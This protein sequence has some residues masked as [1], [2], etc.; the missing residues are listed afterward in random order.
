MEPLNED[1]LRQISDPEFKPESDAIGAGGVQV[2]RFEA[3]NTGQTTLELA[4]RRWWEKAV[5][6][7]RTYSIQVIVR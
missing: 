1:V 6:P 2:L 5:E 7:L 4:Y 3:V